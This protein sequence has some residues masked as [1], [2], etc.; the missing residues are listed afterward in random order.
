MKT[1]PGITVSS[2]I[3]ATLLFTI[4]SMGAA[5]VNTNKWD[6]S[7][8]AGLS[9]TRGN[10]ETLLATIGINGKRKF[11]D[12]E[13]LLGAQGAYGEN[14]VE[15][16]TTGKKTTDK[17]AESLSAFGQYNHEISERWY[18]GVRGDFLHDAI[19][20]LDYRFTISPLAGYYALKQTNRTVKLEAGP[21]GV[22]ERQGDEDNQYAALR[23]GER[24]DN[25]FNDKAKMWQSLEF[26][27]QVD[28]WHN[29]LI[30]AELGAEAA[31]TTQ[32]SLRAVLQDIYDNEPAK[33]RKNNDLKLITSLVYKF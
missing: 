14:T 2:I 31:M 17:T 23:F 24:F 21:S 20:D 33:G 9:L 7:M 5:D 4:S 3:V 29:Y 26:I 25:K 15:D 6:V 30:T 16:K 12:A 22:F 8:A 28:R 27:P 19:A 32:F 11:S 1:P 18:A 10:S 13:I